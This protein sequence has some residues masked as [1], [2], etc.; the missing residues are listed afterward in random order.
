MEISLYLSLAMFTVMGAVMFIQTGMDP[1][2]VMFL[3]IP[4]GYLVSEIIHVRRTMRAS[5]AP[6]EAENS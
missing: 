3:A 1:E 4:G 2:I 6:N 5:L